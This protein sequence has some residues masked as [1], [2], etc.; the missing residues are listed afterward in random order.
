[1]PNFEKSHINY[2]PEDY[3]TGAPEFKKYGGNTMHN[4]EEE[5]RFKTITEFLE[6][7]LRGGEPGFVW[8]GESYGVCFADT[9]YCIARMDGTGEIICDTSDSV[10]E[11]MLDGDRLREVIT[12]VTVI[13]RNI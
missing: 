2:W 8:N 1:M 10:L 11:Y 4:S 3:P 6:C 12:K 7:I 9:G 5:N 13:S